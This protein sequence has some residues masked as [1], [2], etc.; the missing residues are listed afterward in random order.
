[1]KKRKEANKMTKEENERI[2]GKNYRIIRFF[3]DGR[4]RK[5][6]RTYGTLQRA[7]EHCKSPL[8]HGVLRS[9]VRWFDGY[10]EIN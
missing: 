10:T 7:Q 4:P 1:M 3:S 6:I 5:R 9:G 8:T 2:Y